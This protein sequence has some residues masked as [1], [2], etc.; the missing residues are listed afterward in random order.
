MKLRQNFAQ[1]MHADLLLGYLQ[2]NVCSSAA[3]KGKHQLEAHGR[4]HACKLTISM[5]SGPSSPTSEQCFL[6]SEV[7][8]YGAASTTPSVPERLLNMC[9]CISSTSNG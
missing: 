4:A 2:L 9:I 1:D 8:C 7:C 6:A 5:W 3:A